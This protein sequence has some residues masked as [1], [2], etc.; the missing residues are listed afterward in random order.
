MRIIKISVCCKLSLLFCSF[1]SSSST[2]FWTVIFLISPCQRLGE[3]K[4]CRKK[5]NTEYQK[6]YPNI[7]MKSLLKFQ[8]KIYI[9][10][11]QYDGERSKNIT[12]HTHIT[13]YYQLES[14]IEFWDNVNVNI[15]D[16]VKFLK[17]WHCK[18]VP[19]HEMESK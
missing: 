7:S 2:L 11:D 5:L 6:T 19:K 17:Y 13:C 8:H 16:L 1:F 15:R 10:S 9:A 3:I 18:T 14:S 4:I 12:C